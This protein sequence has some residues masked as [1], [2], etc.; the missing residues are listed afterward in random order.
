MNSN[1]FRS[2][3][4]E[5]RQSQATRRVL[6]LFQK[7]ELKFDAGNVFIIMIQM[8][9]NLVFC[10]ACHHEGDGETTGD[11]ISSLCVQ[12]VEAA[13]SRVLHGLLHFC[14]IYF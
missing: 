7:L 12:E 2:H 14:I 8:S 13:V 5:S 3:F 1:K 9:T 10:T 4:L 11:Y 6:C